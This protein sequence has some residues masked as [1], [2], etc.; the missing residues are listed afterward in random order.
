MNGQNLTIFCIHIIIDKINIGIL[1]R[2]F[3]GKFATKL[4]P[5]I[6][7]RIWFMLNALRFSKQNFTKFCIRII[8]DKFNVGIVKRYLLQRRMCTK[9][10][11][12]PPPPPPS[13]A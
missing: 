5:L 4:W 7:V 8:I 10:V 3:F 13:E 1:K 11:F 2:F 6:E 9:P 12:D